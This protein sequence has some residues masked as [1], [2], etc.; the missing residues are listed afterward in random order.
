M[1]EREI[2]D[3]MSYGCL[4]LLANLYLEDLFYSLFVDDLLSSLGKKTEHLMCNEQ[5]ST[6]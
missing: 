3:W 1:V 2:E 4:F 5:R 6:F